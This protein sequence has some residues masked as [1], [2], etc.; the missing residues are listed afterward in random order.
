[1]WRDETYLLDALIAGRRVARYTQGVSWD[2]FREQG[3]LQDAVL[4]NVQIVGE[5]VRKVSAEFRAAHPEIPWE[6]IVG[7]RH[8]LVHDY[9]RID[10]EKVWAA[11]QED[12]PLLMQQFELL[13]PPDEES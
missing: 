12:L 2:S 7:L 10:L 4:H 11:C 5:A 9:F 1:M 3:V 13:V 8:R 6:R